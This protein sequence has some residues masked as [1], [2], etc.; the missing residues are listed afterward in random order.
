M[1]CESCGEREAQ[2]QYTKVE[3]DETTLTH[4]CA[5]CASEHGFGGEM[6]AEAA[7]LADFLAQIGATGA[8][9]SAAPATESCPYCGTSVQDFRKSGRLGCSQCY[10]H[11]GAHLQPLMRRVHGSTQHVGKIYLSPAVEGDDTEARVATLKRRL[12]RA[13]EVEDFEAAA[14]LRDE[15]RELTVVE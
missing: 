14:E 9:T 8:E 7:P 2:I 3:G 1:R 10:V 13:V 4:L 12:D 11:F 5:E 15:I 6:P